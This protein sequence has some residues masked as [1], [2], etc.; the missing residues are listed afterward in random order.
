MCAEQIPDFHCSPRYPGGVITANALSL[1]RQA[2]VLLCGNFRP[3]R[4][5]L[6]TRNVQ[7]ISSSLNDVKVEISG[8][9][10]CTRAAWCAIEALQTSVKMGMSQSASISGWHFKLLFNIYS[11]ECCLFHRFWVRRQS[12]RARPDLSSP[13][14]FS[15]E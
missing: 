10:T 6:A 7:T 11:L 1:Y 15:T 13:T 4:S 8:S 12:I 2:H 9:S 14:E 5:T 3:L